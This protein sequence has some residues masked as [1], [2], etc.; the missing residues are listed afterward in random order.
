MRAFYVPLILCIGSAGCQ[1]IGNTLGP[2]AI[3]EKASYGTGEEIVVTVGSDKTPGSNLVTCC[4]DIAC[5]LDQSAS[6]TWKQTQSIGIPCMRMCPFSV[7]VVEPGHSYSNVLSPINQSGTH[8]LRFLILDTR[9]GVVP[10]EI[11]SNTFT[12][13]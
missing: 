7:F 6:G 1:D 3:T 5:Y 9:D 12:V 8:R 10:S 2:Y 4:G 11:I 13:E